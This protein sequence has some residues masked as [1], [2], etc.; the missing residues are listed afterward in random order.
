MSDF[1]ERAAEEEKPDPNALQELLGQYV[2]ALEKAKQDVEDAERELD[3]RK[4]L[5]RTIQEEELPEL[6]S[7]AGMKTIKMLNGLTVSVKDDVYVRIPKEPEKRQVCLAWLR[8]HGM[9]DI[10]KEDVTLIESETT[11]IDQGLLDTLSGMGLYWEK[12]EDVNP[13][14]LKA[15]FRGLL[16]LQKGTMQTVAK[17]GIPEEFG[18]YET[19]KADI[20]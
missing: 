18:L 10:I 15:T 11:K 4:G 19:H 1:L 12:G 17:E 2:Q 20:K 3:V 7:R 9:K 13:Q 6:L 8:E 5:L 14:T 16:G